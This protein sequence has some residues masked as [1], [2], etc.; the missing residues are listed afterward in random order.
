MAAA[1]AIREAA[2]QRRWEDALNRLL[3]LNQ[4][5]ADRLVRVDEFVRMLQDNPFIAD[6]LG[7]R[8]NAGERVAM[9]KADPSWVGK[10]VVPENRR[11]EFIRILNAYRPDVNWERLIETY[12]ISRVSRPDWREP[13][14]LPPPGMPQYD[15]QGLPVAPPAVD[16]DAN[17]ELARK[18]WYNP[19]WFYNQVKTG[20]PWD[21]KRRFGSHYEDFGNFHYGVVAKA[22][23]FPD[24]ITY[25]EGGIAQY[26]GPTAEPTGQWGRPASRSYYVFPW[27]DG[28]KYPFGD[29]PRDREM[30]SR[31]IRYYNDNY[32][33][34]SEGKW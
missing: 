2:A 30:I 24:F 5:P 27:A 11:N 1:P 19:F 34:K 18:N 12:Q 26:N 21:Y 8:A 3:Q 28:G 7:R 22:F 17:I 6:W 25:N 20:G 15:A 31:G 23:G 29:Q 33:R 13:R 10:L 4:P 32:R 16:I 14:R 9:E